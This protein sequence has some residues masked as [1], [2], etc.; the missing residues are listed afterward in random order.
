MNVVERVNCSLDQTRST[1]HACWA[2]GHLAVLLGRHGQ[3][4]VY[5]DGRGKR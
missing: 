1:E 5:S 2:A 3:L 4:H